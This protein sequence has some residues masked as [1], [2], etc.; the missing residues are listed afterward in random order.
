MK[1]IFFLPLF[2]CTLAT[3]A[4]SERIPSYKSFVYW[5]QANDTI[6][7]EDNTL[8]QESVSPDGLVVV[9]V[10]HEDWKNTVTQKSIAR[11]APWHAVMSRSRGIRAI[12]HQDKSNTDAMMPMKKIPGKMPNA[13]SINNLSKMTDEFDMKYV[14]EYMIE[15]TSEQE[16]VINDLNRGLVW[17]VPRKSYLLLNMGTLPQACLLR[18]ASTDPAQPDIKYVTIGSA[19]L[20][21][22]F[23]VAYEDENCWIY[24]LNEDVEKDKDKLDFSKLMEK[25]NNY[26][27]TVYIKRDKDT[28]QETPMVQEEVFHIIKTAKD[29]REAEKKAKKHKINHPY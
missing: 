29:A 8:M 20:S 22:K 6:Y 13:L 18:I 17:Y 7:E 16:I 5:T 25:N 9:R 3:F 28:F 1:K 15:N 24:L 14:C 2:L 11:L 26:L 4:R 27:H 10:R 19:S 21:M 12:I 23:T